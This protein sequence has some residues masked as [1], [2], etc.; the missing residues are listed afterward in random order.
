M[1][2]TPDENIYQVKLADI[3]TESSKISTTNLANPYKKH[4]TEDKYQVDYWYP[5][6]EY[7]YTFTLSKKGID[8]I[9]VTILDWEKVEASDDE[10]Q[11]Q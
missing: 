9:Q 3:W 4:A 8:N 2:T 5:H 11:I 7:T 10:V 6:Y 1:I